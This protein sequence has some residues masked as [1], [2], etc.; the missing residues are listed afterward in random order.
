MTISRVG[1]AFLG[2]WITGIC[3][4]L[5]EGNADCCQ[6]ARDLV[7]RRI[8][9]RWNCQAKREENQKISSL[10]F[11]KFNEWIVADDRRASSSR[12]A[13]KIHWE[14]NQESWFAFATLFRL[15]NTFYES[16]FLLRRV[17]FP[18]QEDTEEENILV[19]SEV[20]AKPGRKGKL[21]F[22][23]LV[24]SSNLNFLNFVAAQVFLIRSSAG[25]SLV[26]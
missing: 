1:F 13:L 4:S 20:T 26:D 10:R 8:F 22:V 21:K 18:S 9:S 7:V 17:K 2:I 25:K 6:L 24:L 14:I 19:A 5:K 23:I 11:S 12:M 16:A 3:F 15:E